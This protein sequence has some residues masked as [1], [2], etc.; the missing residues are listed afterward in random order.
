[1]YWCN[2]YHRGKDNPFVLFFGSKGGEFPV[3]FT[4][5][6][7]EPSCVRTKVIINTVTYGDIVTRSVTKNGTK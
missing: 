4:P 3:F 1:M 7:K 2:I 5:P 6:L